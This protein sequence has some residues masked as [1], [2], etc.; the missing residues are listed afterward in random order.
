MGKT[1]QELLTPKA[2][3]FVS[4]MNKI[5]GGS[6]RA[7]ASLLGCSQAVISK[8]VNG[9][10]EPGPH[11]I[12]LVRSL[13]GV[14]VEWLVT[15]EGEPLIGGALQSASGTV[16]VVRKLV[17][18]DLRKYPTYAT[19]Y[20]VNVPATCATATIYG[21]EA[22]RC[23]SSESL[24][25]EF[26]RDTDILVVETDPNVWR[27]DVSVL[28]GRLVVVRIES[29]KPP[30]LHRVATLN[31]GGS[32][33]LQPTWPPYHR[34]EII[35]EPMNSSAKRVLDLRNDPPTDSGATQLSDAIR[36]DAIPIDSVVGLVLQLVRIF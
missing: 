3:R 2:Q 4:L 16:S 27:F 6:Q 17:P 28:D 30:K 13:P 9:E 8:I 33:A 15:G 24:A 23:E 36:E 35:E 29:A 34:S 1:K 7:F 32:D 19:G 11:L 31:G 14:N 18:G 25:K 12:R 21:I 26:I 22:G 20:S 5:A 10:Q